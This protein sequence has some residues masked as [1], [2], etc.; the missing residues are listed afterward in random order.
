MV[1]RLHIFAALLLCTLAGFS[2]PGTSWSIVGPVNFPVNV[3]GQIN[4]IGRCTQVK[5]DPVTPSKMYMTSASGGLWTSNDTGKVW[6]NLGTDYFQLMQCASVCIDF[7]NTNTLY[8]G[9]G[10]PN[11]YGGGFGV[12]KSTNGGTTWALSNTGLGNR[13]VVE[14]LM[15]PNNNQILLAATD[16][17]IFR[18]TNAGSSWTSVKSGGDFKA[19]VFKPNSNDTLYAVTSSQVWRSLNAGVSWQQITNGVTVPGGNGQGMRLAVSKQSPNVVYVGMIAD[20]GTILKSVDFGTSFTTVYHNPAQSLVGYDPTTSGQGDYNF[21][22]TA[23]PADANTVY[24]AAHCVWKSTDGGVTWTQLTNWYDRCHTDMHGIVL[25]PYYANMLFDANDGGLFLSRDAGVTWSPRANGIAASEV[26]HAAQSK[27]QRGLLSIGTQ[28]NGELYSQQNAWYTNRGGDWGSKVQFSYNAP[29]V[30]YYYDNGNRRPVSGSE[31]SFNTPFTASNDMCLEFNR[32]LPNMALSSLQ[33]IY[34]CNNITASTPAWTQVGTVTNTFVALHS[35]FADSSVVYALSANN[36][37]YRC[38]N[39]LA[40]SP[41][42]TSY[43]SPGNTNVAASITTVHNNMNVVYVSCGSKVYRSANKG[44]SFTNISSG[45]PTGVNIIQIIHDEYSVNEDV[46]LCT[47]KGVYYRNNSMSSWQ[48]ISYNLPTIADIQE[49]MLYNPGNAAAAIRIAYYGRGVWELPL[50]T[51]QPPAPDFMADKQVICPGLTVHFTDLSI[52]TPAPTSW[53]WTFPGGTPA[54]SS[55][56]NPI[57]TYAT[58]G[59]YQ[60]TLATGNTNGTNTLTKTAYIQVSAPQPPPISEGFAGS[61][62]PPANWTLYDAAQ[63]NVVWQKSTTVG[64]YGTSTESSYFDNYNVDAGDNRDE[65]RTRTYSLAG[66]PNTLLMFDV[67]YARWGPSNSDSLEVLA[68]TD[69]GQT[70]TSLY[71][72]GGTTLATSPDDQA[73]FVPT[74]AQ[75][76][77]ETINLSAYSS[78]SQL[79]FAFR[80]RG[81][82]GNVIYVDNINIPSTTGLEAMQ[83]QQFS[84][85]VYPNPAHQEVQ[86]S[87]AS[88]SGGDCTISISDELGQEIYRKNAV[89]TAG[90]NVVPVSLGRLQA[91]IYLVSVKSNKYLATKK[92][93]VE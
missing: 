61:V 64:G 28:D 82:Y 3:S 67:A 85:S 83:T 90:S 58:P 40:A 20:E 30:A 42:F 56:Q 60:V 18:S 38:D 8:L 34:I 41:T 70:Y 4:G 10:D 45:L 6:Q 24:L 19:M 22:M 69:C 55:A 52:G 84:L 79:L 53:A 25:H 15:N 36:V 92:L 23:D 63:D 87:I 89:L 66:S 12:Y 27:L 57:V 7:S 74:A 72:K 1:Q 75:W 80:N 33:N 5:F 14:L 47:A 16:N 37:L 29:D 9:S 31:T 44:Q 49:I 93:V 35:S 86:L 39:I 48:N 13:L 43:T 73:L 68:S 59:N 17:G 62:F 71:L 88:I 32:K 51:S 91:G 26:Y 46:Y 50:N 77:T 76:R 2:Q 11:Y 21:A 78:A 81:H 65:F 54:T